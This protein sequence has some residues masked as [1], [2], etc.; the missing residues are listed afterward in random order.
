[1]PVLMPAIPS[2]AN[3][4]FEVSPFAIDGGLGGAKL[5]C[6]YWNGRNYAGRFWHRDASLNI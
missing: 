3:Y 2:A 5:V 6:S 4:Y 1:M